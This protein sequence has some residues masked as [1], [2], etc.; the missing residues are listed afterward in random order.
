[1]INKKPSFTAILRGFYSSIIRQMNNLSLKKRDLTRRINVCSVD[2][3]ATAPD[4]INAFCEHL[5]K[6]IREIKSGQNEFS[7]TGMRLEEHA[8]IM[9][10]S[11]TRIADAVEKFFA[12][13]R[14]Q[15]ENINI[16][17][18][19]VNE[20]KTLVE[21]LE[22][23]VVIRPDRKRESA[24]QSRTLQ[25]ANKIIAN[26]AVHTN[27]LAMNAAAEAANAREASR[28]FSVVAAEIRRLAENSSSES[29]KIGAE[30]KQIVATIERIVEDAE[31]SENVFAEVSR[32]I[33][34]TEKKNG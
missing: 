33:S 29:R 12:K 11:V 24:E 19:I 9:A 17:I 7:K 5:N 23:S 15:M 10:D 27:L 4:M 2:E 8:R 32:R 13:T 28:G 3:T 16:S 18:M 31:A 22:R 26:V 25:E 20:L 21:T 6:G 1:M 14:G 30:L 34:E